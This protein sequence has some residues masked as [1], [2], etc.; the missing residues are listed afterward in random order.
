MVSETRHAVPSDPLHLFHTPGLSTAPSTPSGGVFLPLRYV[1]TAHV[2]KEELMSD[3]CWSLYLYGPRQR[4]VAFCL[5][6]KCVMARHEVSPFKGSVHTPSH[7]NTPRPLHSSS[8]ITDCHV[9][10]L[11]CV[12]CRFLARPSN[13]TMDR[14]YRE[15]HRVLDRPRVESDGD[16]A[17][18]N[19]AP[20]VK[21]EH[22]DSG[23]DISQYISQQP[24][25]VQQP[26]TPSSLRSTVPAEAVTAPDSNLSVRTAPTSHASTVSHTTDGRTVV[27]GDHASVV[28]LPLQSSHI[29]CRWVVGLGKWIYDCSVCG[30]MF[31]HSSKAHEHIASQHHEYNVPTMSEDGRVRFDVPVLSS[32]QYW[33]ASSPPP[34]AHTEHTNHHHSTGWASYQ[35]AVSPERAPL[36]LPRTRSVLFASPS[37][38]IWLPPRPPRLRLPTFPPLTLQLKARSWM[39]FPSSISSL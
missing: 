31:K 11:L 36:R 1:E 38:Q 15:Q 3:T 20:S 19:S 9:T 16:T 7:T 28:R 29:I 5:H 32:A 8:M 14:H 39:A 23:S 35:S 30:K 4:V 33:T 18:A 21:A 37:Q 17:S 27:S 10:T 13:A 24:Q 25:Q 6:D 26:A 2:R 22:D 12:G 34:A